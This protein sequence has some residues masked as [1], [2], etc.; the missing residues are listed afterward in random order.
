MKR[1][2]INDVARRAG[3]SKTTV[4]HVINNTRFVED[5]TRQ[6]VIRSIAELGYHPS[7]IA[8]SLTSK[9]TK[10]VGLLVSDVGNPFYPEVIRGVEE[11]AIENGYQIFFGNT[12]YDLD[13]SMRLIHSLIEKQVDGVMCMSS[14]VSVELIQELNRHAIPAV[15]MDWE[16]SNINKLAASIYIDFQTGI[17]Q[18]VE[19]L[20]SLG[21]QKIAHI[22][23]PLHLWT[24]QKRKEIFFNAL[25]EHGIDPSNSV[26][27]EGNLR[28]DGGRRA[29]PGLLKC[30]NRPTAVFAANDLTAMG[31]I[32]EAREQGISIPAELSVIGLD[33]IELAS[34]ITPQLTTVVLPRYQIGCLAMEILLEMLEAS[35]DQRC[36][37]LEN[38]KTVATR[39]VVRESTASP[40]EHG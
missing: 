2:T 29:L 21:H 9:R 22:S 13:R 28:I 10:T 30:S 16:V 35:D 11:I 34:T 32:W 33:D 27:I 12:N 14:I 31:L 3:V 39:L 15:V 6:R 38:V 1:V 7:S 23:G 36:A 8:R 18:A 40:A 24:A 19:H 20:V 37:I 4:S 17:S 5:G 26:I 25:S